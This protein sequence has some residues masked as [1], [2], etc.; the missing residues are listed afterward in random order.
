MEVSIGWDVGGAHLKAARVEG[1]CV[2]A[3]VQ[4][5]C[6]L[7]QGIERLHEA[8]PQA[9]AVVGETSNHAVTMTGELVDLFASREEGVRSL[10]C[11]LSEILAPAR[12]HLYA[13]PEGFVSVDAA[14]GNARAIASAN[15]H[16]SAS[17][18][19]RKLENALFVD[20]GSTTTDVLPVSRGSVVAEGYT[21]GERLV[22]GE[23]IY[24]GL[25]RSFLMAVSDRAP[26]RGR[27]VPLMNEYF[28]SMADVFRVLGELVEEVDQH[29][30]ADGREKTAPASRARLARMIGADA[31][32]GDDEDWRRLAEWFAEAQLRAIEDG[33]RQVLSRGVLRG[34]CSVVGAGIGLPVVR[35]L[36]LRLGLPFQSFSAR[37]DVSET[38]RPWADCCAPAVAVA[39]LD[40]LRG[41]GK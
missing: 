4:V 23:L 28:A 5:P 26:F 25:T 29:P 7:W 17:L 15:W 11:A 10:A 39:L 36:A 38:A 14:A 33:A 37:M 6:P 20:M 19:A 18:V 30:A 3:V 2:R 16:A 41:G 13:G 34:E 1:Q 27:W 31:S 24:S 22:S 32:D 35:R 8:V 9:L 12:V 40:A 21:D